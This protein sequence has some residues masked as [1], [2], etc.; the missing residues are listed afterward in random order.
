MEGRG[1]LKDSS[2]PTGT[3]IF[4]IKGQCRNTVRNGLTSDYTNSSEKLSQDPRAIKSIHVSQSHRHRLRIVLR[5]AVPADNPL[6][7]RLVTSVS[8]AVALVF[9]SPMKFRGLA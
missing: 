5:A 6:K 1:H 3:E 4:F 8:R 7:S 9:P 2:D